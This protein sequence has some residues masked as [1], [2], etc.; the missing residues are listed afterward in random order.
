MTEANA[1]I[2]PP[3]DLYY[4]SPPIPSEDLH[5]R[6]IYLTIDTFQG[7]TAEGIFRLSATRHPDMPE[8]CVIKGGP[9][10]DFL[11]SYWVTFDAARA[12][13]IRRSTSTAYDFE[14]DLR[15]LPALAQDSLIYQDVARQFQESLSARSRTHLG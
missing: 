5:G 13:R 2:F 9:I 10:G 15:G 7:C 6:T 12:A 3:D 14:A 1:A 4:V 11:V 8:Y